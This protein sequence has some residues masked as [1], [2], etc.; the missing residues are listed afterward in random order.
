MNS[1]PSFF[2]V[3]PT[4][5]SSSILRG[6]VRSLRDQTYPYWRVHFVDGDSCESHREY[7]KELS[8]LDSRMTF[9]LQDV[10]SRGIYGA[11]NQGANLA[12]QHEWTV[13]LGSDDYLESSTTLSSLA[14]LL[15]TQLQPVDLVV[16]SCDYI[17]H[18]GSF[19]RRSTFGRPGL[20]ASSHF[21][22]RLY[23]GLT[24]P[25]QGSVFS[26]RALER[27]LPYDLNLVLASDLD[28]FWRMSEIPEF[29]SLVAPLVLA[30]LTIGG[31]SHQKTRLRFSE[32]KKVLKKYSG[33]LWVFVFLSRYAYRFYSRINPF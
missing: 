16:C 33:P 23:S 20:L 13:F 26:P 21:R 2:F 22:L 8:R 15:S 3:V 14:S 5:N 11:M 31:E 19:L 6:L 30:K 9:S 18:S 27:M 32:V 10:A 28:C 24:P 17:E 12:Q 7:L 4:L 1:N 29:T 25:H